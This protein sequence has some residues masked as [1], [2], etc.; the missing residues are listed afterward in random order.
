MSRQAGSIRQTRHALLAIARTGVLLL[1]YTCVG[2]CAGARIALDGG[3]GAG[4]G[5]SRL[6]A[7]HGGVHSP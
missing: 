7:F 1:L 2:S 4:L 5:A 6:T 3:R